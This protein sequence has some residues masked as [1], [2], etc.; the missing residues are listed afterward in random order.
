MGPHDLRSDLITQ[1]T[2][3]LA[4]RDSKLPVEMSL[5]RAFTT[6][7]NKPEMEISTPMFIGRA[8]SQ[9]AGKPVIRAQISSPMALVS[10]SNV[11]LNKA[12][13]IAGTSPIDMRNVSSGSSVVSSSS[14]DSDTSTGSL[15]SRDTITDASSVDESPI[16]PEPNHLSCYFKPSVDTQTK[17]SP[18]HSPSSSTRPSLDT[19]RLPQR[20]PSH[21]KKAHEHLHRK[22]S[23]QR[24]LSPAATAREAFRDNIES[25]AMFSPTKSSF[26]EAP[27]E[28]PF[29]RELAQL[30]EV[31]E[32]FGNVVRDAEAEADFK[33]MKAYDLAQYGASDYMSEIHSLILA[34][35]EEEPVQDLGGWI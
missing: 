16:Q 13:H 35:F 26:V 2:S 18:A 30:D 5:A 28:S 23:V 1:P 32:E 4:D 21:S 10:T 33:V 8:A 3:N 9:R 31:A 14:E 19:P 34:T 29:G 7:R 6:R 11:M 24:M 27:K 17:T 12:H 15:H 20:I 22:R 25:A